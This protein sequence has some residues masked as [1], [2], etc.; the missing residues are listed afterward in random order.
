MRFH[1]AQPPEESGLFLSPSRSG[2]GRARAVRVE[3]HNGKLPCQWMPVSGTMEH[4]RTIRDHD[5]VWIGARCFGRC[6][7]ALIVPVAK[8][9][10]GRHNLESY[11]GPIRPLTYSDSG[12][13]G[14]DS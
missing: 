12:S 7:G 6:D 2:A 10:Q 13:V 11:G 9:S 1:E 5:V 8:G 14:P 4:L 3:H